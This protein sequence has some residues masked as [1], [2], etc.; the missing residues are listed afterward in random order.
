MGG[1]SRGNNYLEGIGA[2]TGSVLELRGGDAGNQVSL[3]GCSGG[4]GGTGIQPQGWGDPNL[5]PAQVVAQ[6]N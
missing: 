4:L 5:R 6:E 2:G 1:P 3:A